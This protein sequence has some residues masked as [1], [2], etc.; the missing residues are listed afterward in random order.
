MIR[1]PLNELRSLYRLLGTEQ[2]LRLRW[3]FQLR[4][5]HEDE[6]DYCEARIQLIDQELT[7][8]N[9]TLRI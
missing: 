2:L 3:A 7:A 9:T 8:R 6:R 5:L 1:D 4:A